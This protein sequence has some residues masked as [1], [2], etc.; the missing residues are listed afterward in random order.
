M[1][2]IGHHLYRGEAGGSLAGL[3]TQNIGKSNATRNGTRPAKKEARKE[4]QIAKK[5]RNSS[6]RNNSEEERSPQRVEEC[7]AY[8]DT[9]RQLRMC[10]IFYCSA[11][12]FLC[13][14]PPFTSPR[15]HPPTH[16]LL[17]SFSPPVSLP[18]PAFVAECDWL[19]SADIIYFVSWNGGGRYP[20]S[21]VHR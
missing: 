5:E 20:S 12:F 2:V 11:T 19:P 7:V 21:Y 1:I 16:P 13:P 17:P 14:P 9:G 8:Q 3:P 4:R 6:S 15:T 10:I 18:A